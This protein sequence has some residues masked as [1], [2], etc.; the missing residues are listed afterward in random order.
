MKGKRA[1][2]SV[3][4]SMK[5]G[6]RIAMTATDGCRYTKKILTTGTSLMFLHALMWPTRSDGQRLGMILISA[7]SS[8]TGAIFSKSIGGKTDK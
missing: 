3:K 5:N 4:M 2:S 7:G 6:D 8:V 1:L